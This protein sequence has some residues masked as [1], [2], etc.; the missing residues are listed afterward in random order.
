MSKIW[1]QTPDGRPIAGD[2]RPDHQPGHSAVS[3]LGE[4]G[5]PEL[6]RFIQGCSMLLPEAAEE[7]GP[8]TGF[9]LFV[10]GAADHYWQRFQLDDALYGSYSERLLRRFG[11]DWEQAA[12]LV[13]ALPRL[14]RQG[15]AWDALCNGAETLALWL[16]S[17][18]TNV[19]LRVQDLVPQWRRIKVE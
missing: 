5:T 17:H 3:E 19:L 2:Y 8:R 7:P 9:Y 4:T 18:D 6:E 13:E 15:P 16:D 10:L 14:P 12:A 1:Q 11:L